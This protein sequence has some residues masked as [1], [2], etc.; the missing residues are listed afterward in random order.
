MTT[1]AWDDRSDFDDVAQGFIA[2]LD[3]PVVKDAHGRPVWDCSRYDF[4]DAECP[5]T[6]NPSLWRQGQ[7][8]AK[9]GLFQ[10]TKGIYQ[11][12]GLDLSNMTLVEGDTGIIVIDTLMS[13]ETAAAALALYRSHRGDRPVAAV[14]IT[15]SHADHYG[16]VAAVAEADT[17]IYA[18]AGFLD[19]AVSEN[20][21]AG[22]AMSRRAAYIYAADLPASATGQIGCGL[23]MATSFGTMSLMVPT[24][25]VTE[26]G[27]EA[28]ID[29]VRVVFQITPGTE[30]PAEMNFFFPDQRALCMAENATHTLHQVLTL[31][32]AEVRD[33]RAWSRYLGEALRLFGADTDVVFASHHWPVWGTERIAHFISQQRD[34]YCYMHDQT[35][36]RMNQGQIGTEIAEE[37]E[38]P[39]AL[40][41]A[42]HARGYYGSFSHNIKAIYQRYLGW[43]DGNPAHLWLY[44]PEEEAT[45]YVEFMGGADAVLE[46]AQGSF[47]AGDLRWTATVV[48]HV[49]FADPDNAAARELLAKALEGLGYGAENGLWR[50]IYLRGVEELRGPIAAAP[51]DTA[52]PQ[53]LGALTIE[54]L[55]DSIGIRIDGERAADA[56]VSID[57]VFTDASRT[58]RTTLSNGAFIHSDAGYGGGDPQLTLTLTKPQLLGLLA[59]GGLDGIE[60]TGDPGVLPTLLGLLDTVDH[61]FAIVTP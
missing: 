1:L 7:L 57:W 26:T 24:V 2:T 56:E 29:G 49:V 28:V 35:L 38:L 45:R 39:P 48:S 55:F 40:D 12:R 50:N 44:P 10:V 27:Q 33:S 54:Q 5:P 51:P 25:D 60:H 9:H 53:V 32:G 52:S 18:P 19:H 15:H 36:R 8:V 61:Q 37:F 11:V 59:G 34:T 6:A 23:G 47:D 16:G 58:Y 13:N 46:K 41:Q 17:P 4:M 22:A 14:I 31:R 43:Y 20:V 42:W 3:D 30:A 21:Y